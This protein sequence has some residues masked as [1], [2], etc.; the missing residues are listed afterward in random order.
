M[1]RTNCPTDDE[2]R[3]F[4]S[5]R[6]SGEAVDKLALHVEECADCESRL[7]QL[8][9]SADD[10][11]AG[12]RGCAASPENSNDFAVPALVAEAVDGVATLSRRALELIQ[13]NFEE[14][15]WNAFWKVAVEGRPAAAVA[16][17]LDMK[18]GT[19]RV[20]RCRVLARLRE[21]F[22]DLIEGDDQN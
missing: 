12:V 9:D 15:T 20:S 17:E 4:G 14:R 7:G 18:P 5:G 19:V 6:L 1:I 3:A 22:G 11:V 13:Q 8:D 21:E 16:E 2:L 10:F